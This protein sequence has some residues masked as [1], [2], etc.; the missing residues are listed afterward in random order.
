MFVVSD[1]SLL[2]YLVL[3]EAAAKQLGLAV[4]GALGVLE[5][6]AEQGFLSLPAA[7]DELRRTT[8]RAPER[9][10]AEMLRRDQLRNPRTTPEPG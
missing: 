10:I 7:I 3:V 6:A 9:L 2:N 1:T 4:A 5:L 8:F